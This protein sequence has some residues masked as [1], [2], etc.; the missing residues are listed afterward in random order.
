MSQL[1]RQDSWAE[2]PGPDR[3]EARHANAHTEEHIDPRSFCSNCTEDL[4]V[5]EEILICP[6]H[7]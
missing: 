5:C 7:V 1:T 3:Y 4:T 2:E 6:N